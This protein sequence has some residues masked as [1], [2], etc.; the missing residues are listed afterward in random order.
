MIAYEDLVSALNSWRTRNGMP[1]TPPDY[2]E[3]VDVQYD[4]GAPADVYDLS[5]DSGLIMT[6]DV[7]EEGVIETGVE[8]A[9]TAEEA[10]ESEYDD[11][12]G[13]DAYGYG[14]YQSAG[15]ETD[16]APAD[17]GGYAE[18]QAVEGDS[19]QDDPAYETAPVDIDEAGVQ[20]DEEYLAD[21]S[22]D[23]PPYGETLDADE[24]VLEEQLMDAADGEELDGA[25]MV[26]D[27]PDQYDDAAEYI[28]EPDE[29]PPMPGDDDEPKP[30]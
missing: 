20:V 25:T 5:E 4:D 6:E 14:E 16:D 27:E 26:A 28:D 21:G 2:G 13:T 10:R 8:I 7:V 19:Y 9:T 29:L 11:P 22:G 24:E 3:P 12:P 15:A 18:P 23:E 17:Y 1:T 30:K